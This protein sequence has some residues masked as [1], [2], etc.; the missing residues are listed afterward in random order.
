MT[1][2][3]SFLRVSSDGWLWLEAFLLG[4]VKTFLELCCN[5]RLYLSNPLSFPLFFTGVETA[6]WSDSPYFLWLPSFFSS[7][8]HNSINLL[9]IM[10][11]W[12]L[13][14]RGPKL[15]KGSSQSWFLYEWRCGFWKYLRVRFEIK[16]NMHGRRYMRGD[17]EILIVL[18]LDLYNRR[19]ASFRFPQKCKDKCQALMS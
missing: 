11:S 10:L 14:Y 1:E 12:S 13:L 2:C 5:L 19:S 17:M 18:N 4:L 15:I 8:S 9:H 3:G 16:S 7:Q 6:L